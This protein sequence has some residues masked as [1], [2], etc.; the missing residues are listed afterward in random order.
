VLLAAGSPAQA[1][2][3][4]VP[5]SRGYSILSWPLSVRRPRRR[6]GP[7]SLPRV[8][9]A[10]EHVDTGSGAVGTT[11]RWPGAAPSWPSAVRCWRRPVGMLVASCVLLIAGGGGIHTIWDLGIW[12]CID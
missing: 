10:Q 2:G 6:D 4:R 9:A 12:T 7:P 1:L 5:L 8:A 3:H 11:H